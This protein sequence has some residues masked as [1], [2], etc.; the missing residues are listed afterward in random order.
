MSVLEELTIADIIEESN[1]FFEKLSNLRRSF[2]QIAELSW[3][4]VQTM[5]LIEQH[6]DSIRTEYQLPLTLQHFHGGLV[7]DLDFNPT[8][9]KL[10]FRADIDALPIEEKT[11]SNFSSQN[12]GVMH[13][14][15]H[16]FHIAMLLIA[17][18]IIAKRKKKPPNNFR[19]VFQ[20]AEETG[21]ENCGGKVLVDEGVLTNVDHVVGLHISATAENGIFFSKP[22]A[23]L[24]NTAMI[25]LS[26]ECSGGHVMHPHEGS[27]AIDILADILVSIKGIESRLLS[28]LSQIA[29]VPSRIQ[30]GNACNIRPNFGTLSLALRNF[31][32]PDHFDHLLVGIKNK[33][34][35]VIAGYPTAK[36]TKFGVEKG[37][38]ALINHPSSYLQI[39]NVLNEAF[40]VKESNPLFAGED[41]AYYLEQKLGSYWILGAKNKE[42]HDHHTATFDPDE[43]IMTKGVAFWLMIAYFT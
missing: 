2:H 6:L 14:C 36:L 39:A 25:E 27:N 26:L 5:Q 21:N 17:I 38:P 13:A 20:R 10:L 4:E 12:K 40:I 31:L 35:A 42:G 23:M 16:D 7:A 33:I 22:G 11:G 37:Y 41:F 32:Q 1:V 30:A 18:E 43:A 19:F 9:K 8:H 15:G 34:E 24:A 28:P 3:K 29:L